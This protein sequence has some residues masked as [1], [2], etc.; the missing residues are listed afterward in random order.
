M[1]ARFTALLLAPLFVLAFCAGAIAK[2]GHQDVTFDP[3]KFQK[4]REVL[5][6]ALHSKT[7][8]EITDE[9]KTK[10]IEALNRMGDKLAN[11]N[12]LSEL[13]EKDK[14]AV[15]NDQSVINAL[16]TEAAADSQLVCK[17][18]KKLGSNMPTNVCMTVAQRREAQRKAQDEL[19]TKFRGARLQGE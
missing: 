9:N 4:Q 6:D 8:F 3:A 14:V 13:S 17:R 12:S 2:E 11:V 10:V 15:F 1:S 19:R 16:L 18:E 5:I 7:Y